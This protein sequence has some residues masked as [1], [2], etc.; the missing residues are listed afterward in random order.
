[1]TDVLPPAGFGIRIDGS[2]RRVDRG[3]ILIGGA[4]LRIMKLSAVGADLV[5]SWVDGEPLGPNPAHRKLARRLLDAGMAHPR[6]IA[7]RPLDVTVIVPVYDNV[8][9]LDRCLR[10]LGDVP[11]VVVDDA[12]SDAVSHRRVARDHSAEYIRRADNGGPGAARV[13]GMDSIKSEFVA[14]VDSDLEVRSGWL[15]GLCG[16]FDDPAVVAVA[17]RVRSRRAPGLLA[18]HE[19]FHSPLDLGEVPGNVGPGRA[20][21]Y[22]PT[23]ALVARTAAIEAVGG[24]DPDLRWGEDVDLIWRLTDAGGVVRYEPSV[25]VVHDPRPD[26]RG[27][28]NQRRRYGASAASLAKRH[29]SKVAPARCSWWSAGAWAMNLA[30]HPVAGAAVAAGSTAALTRK[31]ESIPHPTAEAVRLAG[32]GHMYAGLGLD[33]ATARVWWP[34]ALLL[35]AWRPNLRKGITVAIL[36]PAIVDWAS[37]KRPAG[38]AK[39]I[40]LRT[41]DHMA[42]GVGVWEGVLRERTITPL[43]PDFSEWPGRT[44]AVDETTVSER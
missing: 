11:T 40:F 1:V 36:T 24:F 18:A 16:H 6:P 31:L 35:A 30:G 4:P 25:E 14:F 34:P 3:R 29:G 32:R 27:W 8:D 22:V 2:V 44:A 26:W 41:L 42:Y 43:L 37:G 9:G 17:P 19:R 7:V 10:A 38:A 12:S 13:T 21:S 39:S 33:R 23:A 15:S 28:L 5:D 20:I